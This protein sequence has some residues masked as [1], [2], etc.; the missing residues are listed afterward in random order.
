[1]FS[2]P[3]QANCVNVVIQVLTSIDFCVK[4]TQKL[5][6]FKQLNK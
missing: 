4:K 3:N 1:M 6:R 2:N 5:E